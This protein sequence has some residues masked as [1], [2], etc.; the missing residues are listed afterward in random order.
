MSKKISHGDP[1]STKAARTRDRILAT[2]QREASIRGIDGLTIGGLAEL[3][4]M[5]KSGLNAH[6]GSK[7]ALQLAV[8]D[9]TAERFRNDVV[10]P[11]LA[12]SPG[13]KQ[14]EALMSRWID[15]S[16]H[17]DR[18]GGCQLIAAAFDFDALDGAVSER[19]AEWLGAW[20]GAIVR[21]V[22]LANRVDGGARDAER[23][24]SLAFGLY[25]SQHMERFLLGDADAARRAERS[26][27]SAI[28]A[29]V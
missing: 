23:L 21:A 9:F 13:L 27:Q 2:A 11:S 7:E 24:A 28:R 25:M 15:W 3:S 14:L 17:P 6:F 29:E 16:Q 12:G 1:R 26:W 22:L 18:P 5:S 4:G 20:R 19:L 10:T 8:I